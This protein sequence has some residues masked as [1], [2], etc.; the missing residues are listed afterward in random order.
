MRGN[1][2]LYVCTDRTSPG[3]TNFS[4]AI[5]T[6]FL[7]FFFYIISLLF[8]AVFDLYIVVY[9]I[10]SYQQSSY[11]PP[12]TSMDL[13]QLSCFPHNNS[14]HTTYFQQARCRLNKVKE[15][16]L[17]IRIMSLGSLSV[18]PVARSH[19]PVLPPATDMLHRTSEYE[20]F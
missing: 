8:S 1:N 17:K 3:Q 11:L 2:C 20:N 15:R 6:F 9:Y 16:K 5:N 13:L 7:D 18:F 10:L 14:P 12:D 19:H 4:M